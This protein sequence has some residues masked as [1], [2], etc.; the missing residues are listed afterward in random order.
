MENYSYPRVKVMCLFNKDGKTLAARCVDSRF[1][2]GVF[3][4]VLGGS[5]EMN[6][7]IEEGIRREIQEEL[8]SEVEN[9]KFIRVIENRFVYQSI[10]GHE[11]IFMYSGDLVRKELYD[12]EEFEVIDNPQV[13]DSYK[14]TAA[15][16]SIDDVLVGKK[17][18][19]PDVKSCLQ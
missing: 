16:I 19:F 10:P 15:W 18:L 13:S 7:S 17:T 9:L 6:E 4:R 8:L 5:L 3:Y 12:L 14:F 1:E 11:I 2:D